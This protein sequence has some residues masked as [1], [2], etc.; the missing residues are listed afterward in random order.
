M[1]SALRYTFLLLLVLFLVLICGG[2][3]VNSWLPPLARYLLPNSLHLTLEGKIKTT[4]LGVVLPNISISSQ[5]CQLVSITQPHLGF[6]LSPLQLTTKQVVVD[7][8]CLQAWQTTSQASDN[9][10][11]SLASLQQALPSFAVN[12]D[13]LTVT[14]YSHY[15]GK[16]R[17]SSAGNYQQLHYQGE[18]VQLDLQLQGNQ[19]AINHF[20]LATPQLYQPLRLSGQLTLFDQLTS[21][22][23]NF[24]LQALVAIPTYPRP[25][26]I[27]VQ[28]QQQQGLITIDD[29]QQNVQLLSAP[30]QITPQQMQIT[31][32]KWAWPNPSQTFSGQFSLQANNW[33]QGLEHAEISG[34]ANILTAGRGGKGNLVLSLGPGKLSYTDNQFPLRLT[35]TVKLARLLSYAGL[36]ATLTGALTQPTIR[37]SPGSLLL[38]RGEILPGWQVDEARWPL[39]GVRLNQQGISGALQANLKVRNERS[40]FYSLHMAGTADNF[41]PDKGHWDWRYWGK[42]R[43]IPL[44]ANWDVAGRGYWHDETITLTALTTGFDQIRYGQVVMNKPRMRLSAPIQWSTQPGKLAFNGKFGLTASTT[45]F[46]QVSYLP[47]AKLDVEVAGTT[48]NQFGFKGQLV[49]DNIGPLRISG[50]RDDQHWLG[51]A[52]WPQ[53]SLQVFQP[54]IGARESIGLRDGTIRGQAAFSMAPNTGFQAGGHWVVQQGQVWM[55]DYQFNGIN[56]SLPFRFTD[57]RWQ[58]G[59]QGPVSLQIAQIKNKFPMQDVS[60][61]LRGNW[62]WD[63]AHPIKF[64]DISAQ[65]FGGQIAIPSLQLPQQQV[66]LL[67]IDHLGMSQLI[68]AIHPK[69]IAMSGSVSGELP[70]WL[71]NSPW[72]IDN[73]WIKNDGHLTLRVDKDLIDTILKNNIAAGAAIDWLRYMEIATAMAQLKVDA[74]GGLLMRSTVAGTSRFNH[75]DQRVQLNYQHNENLFMLWRSLSYG[76]NLQSWLEE[77]TRLPAKG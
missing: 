63:D 40:S 61:K 35:G 1:S 5:H 42:G 7:S 46:G 30:W 54:L 56:V 74:Q 14:P 31:Q 11:L 60:V 27:A 58:F 9:A 49:S 28:R 8:Q 77:Q 37:F 45:Q 65:L 57:H 24:T 47:P 71:E 34:R 10:P 64:T 16:L 51:Q 2:L 13:Q 39:A 29:K 20:Q 36:P 72:L 15:Q 52:W 4:H 43:V 12:I 25:L 53:Q 18:N 70:F 67:K 26:S 66:A 6:S 55:T 75:R 68:T 76:D 69:Q 23:D 50:R 62:P 44:N 48:P 32:G 33:L 19:L 38:M 73:G 59:V 17:L 22:P 3:T 21:L 41:L